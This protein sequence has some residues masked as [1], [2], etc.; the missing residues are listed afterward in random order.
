[1]TNIQNVATK[2]EVTLPISSNDHCNVGLHLNVKI[3]NLKTYNRILWLSKKADFVQFR[4][5]LARTDFDQC[6]V[7]DDVD[8]SC[9]R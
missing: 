1:M 9:E 2:V 3:R 6:F 7:E 5:S 4:N 8:I